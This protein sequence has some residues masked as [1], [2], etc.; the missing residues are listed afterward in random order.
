[1]F[2][3]LFYSKEAAGYFIAKNKEKAI[4]DLNYLN[5]T[6][7]GNSI[8]SFDFKKLYTNLPHDKVI[9]KL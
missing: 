9:E 7:N 8:M 4:G 1:L 5:H 2:L 6:F 3:L